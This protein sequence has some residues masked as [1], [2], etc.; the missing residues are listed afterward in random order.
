MDYELDIDPRHL[1]DWLKA[2][3]Q[4][5]GGDRFDVIASRTFVE[6]PGALRDGSSEDETAVITAI[7]TLEVRPKLESPEAFFY[8]SVVVSCLKENTRNVN[9]GLE[10][11]GLEL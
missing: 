5:A 1:V 7:G 8:T 11:A 4:V 3:R 10:Q 2:D 9:A 6:E